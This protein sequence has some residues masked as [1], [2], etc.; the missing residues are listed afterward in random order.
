MG[1]WE[2]FRKIVAPDQP[3]AAAP[4]QQVAPVRRVNT[5]PAPSPVPAVQVPTWVPP[6]R[7]VQI[8]RYSVPGGMVYTGPVPRELWGTDQM[9]ECID[10]ALKVNYSNP[11][12]VGRGMPY[13]PAV[14]LSRDVHETVVR[15]PK[16]AGRF[17]TDRRIRIPS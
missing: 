8:G 3:V 6:G 5:W 16:C 4:V 11:D 10:P 12:R 9:P 2:R 1:F 15:T 14:L 17:V 7:T 13:W